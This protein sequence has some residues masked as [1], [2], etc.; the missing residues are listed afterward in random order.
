MG[1]LSSGNFTYLNL[2]MERKN[3]IL[4]G[5]KL[6]RGQNYF[7]QCQLHAMVSKEIPFIR[8]PSKVE[9]AWLPITEVHDKPG[10][11]P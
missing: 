8:T 10:I 5:H 3:V 2:Q 6:S 1:P 7:Q 11:K 4:F 9:V